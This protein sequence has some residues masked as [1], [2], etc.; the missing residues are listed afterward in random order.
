EAGDKPGR[1]ELAAGR[2]DDRVDQAE[3][4]IPVRI[5]GKLG[6]TCNPATHH[7]LVLADRLG[8][9]RIDE[10][11][12][13]QRKHTVTDAIGIGE[14]EHRLETYFTQ[15]GWAGSRDNVGIFDLHNHTSITLFL[16]ATSPS[17]CTLRGDGHLSSSGSRA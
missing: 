13:L 3:D 17:H 1:R 14:N 15:G 2:P 9:V 16:K 7:C 10:A 8:I 6:S 11:A 4:C 12:P 5:R